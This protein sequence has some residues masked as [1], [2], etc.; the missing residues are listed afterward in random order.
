MGSPEK[1]SSGEPA[2]RQ[3]S[4]YVLEFS[5][6]HGGSRMA[7][8]HAFGDLDALRASF[9]RRC[10]RFGEPGGVDAYLVMWY[11]AVLHLWVVQ[12]GAI[13]EGIDLHPYLR[14]GNPRYDEALAR[15]LDIQRQGIEDDEWNGLF[16]LIS[17]AFAY[18]MAAALPLI[19]RVFDL[20]DRTAAGDA[21][22]PAELASVTASLAD[23]VESGVAPTSLHGATD[24]RL[25]LDWDG[26]AAIAP[27]LD[28]P[29]LMSDATALRWSLT[30]PEHLETHLRFARRLHLGLNDL[31]FGFD[32]HPDGEKAPLPRGWHWFIAAG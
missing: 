9:E 4:C 29:V 10:A 2:I 24:V 3:V 5:V 1:A 32:Q 21:D 13:V 30:C 31:E 12:L 11:G 25:V 16:D 8:V 14:T 19:S 23:A 27:T 22:A 15:L 17:Q 20:R 18:D 26:I 28:K 6:D 7:D